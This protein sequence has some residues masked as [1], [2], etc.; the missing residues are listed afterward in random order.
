M[1]SPADSDLDDTHLCIKCNSTIVGITNYIDHRKVNCVTVKNIH[2]IH[3]DHAYGTFVSDFSVP[4]TNYDIDHDHDHHHHHDDQ[5]PSVS[6]KDLSSTFKS[7]EANKSLSDQYDYNYELGADIFF[8]SLQLQSSTKLKQT[9]STVTS[10]NK[11]LTNAI[12]GEKPASTGTTSQA[13]TDKL[14]KAVNDISGTKRVDSVFNLMRYG[15]DSPEPFDD[16]DEDDDDYHHSSPHQHPDHGQRVPIQH[17]GGKWKPSAH[18]S[19]IYERRRLLTNSPQHWFERDHWEIGEEPTTTHD[20]SIDFLQPP[21]SYTK[22]K[23]VPGTKIT[24]LDYK[25]DPKPASKIFTDKYWCATCNRKLASLVVY[26]RHLKSNL[27]KKRSQPEAELDEASRPINYLDS[28]KRTVKPSIYLNDTLYATHLTKPE[29]KT[30]T[31]TTTTAAAPKIPSTVTSGALEEILQQPSSPPPP[32]GKRKRRRNFIKCEVCNTRLPKYLLAKHLISHYHYRRM[33]KNPTLSY[34]IILKNMPKIVHQSPFQ[35]HPC[36]FYANT[37]DMFIAHWSA[38]SHTD[39]TEGPGRFWCSFCKFE[40]EDNN[41]MRRH[42]TAEDHQEVVLAINRSVPIIIRKRT[43]IKC[44]KCLNDFHYNIELRHHA[45][46]CTGAVPIGTASNEYQSKYRC[47]VCQLVVQSRIALQRHKIRK[48]DKKTYF[49][50]PCDLSFEQA[51][52]AKRHRITTE[53]KIQSARARM[54]NSKLM[55]KCKFCQDMFED[56]LKLK[57]HVNEQ[58]PNELAR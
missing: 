52:Q 14:L 35:C 53:H 56:L 33:H 40:C 37:E 5:V 11:P 26:E 50:S 31:A 23:W 36:R 9:T 39:L 4:T 7:D 47:S 45:L 34:G 55:R 12:A 41:Q 42:L 18:T 13:H 8:S 17:T 32:P 21:P 15:Q 49:C 20:D 3:E 24:R 51:D 43:I 44:E 30:A 2:P 29:R 22:G 58:H 10:S 16:D 1:L 57:E 27:H 54:Q 25:P 28:A 19:Q 48:H 46:R 6:G 38:K